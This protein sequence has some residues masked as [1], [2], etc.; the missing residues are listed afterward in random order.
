MRH[1]KSRDAL[2]N[3]SAF[4]SHNCGNGAGELNNEVHPRA[5][6]VKR[7]SATDGPFTGATPRTV[8]IDLSLELLGR[9]RSELTS[10]GTLTAY[11]G[12]A[13]AEELADG[14]AAP[15]TAHSPGNLPTRLRLHSVADVYNG[16]K[17][18]N[19]PRALTKNLF[20]F[21]PRNQPRMSQS[22]QPEASKREHRELV[23]V[24]TRYGSAWG[25]KACQLG[26]VVIAQVRR[27]SEI[28]SS[29]R[30]HFNRK[31]TVAENVASAC[32]ERLVFPR[33]LVIAIFRKQSQSPH[34]SRCP[35]DV[36][37]ARSRANQ[38]K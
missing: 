23:L 1:A 34:V 12:R 38:L 2:K 6:G 4:L 19:R 17:I 20:I 33:N 36:D 16:F 29:H 8:V 9:G 15:R 10:L 3:L 13:Y 11:L 32:L 25:C 28:Y 18:A 30:G 27:A 14:L 31:N 24:N 7:L 21:E 37:R 5:R 26:S 22:E 35:D